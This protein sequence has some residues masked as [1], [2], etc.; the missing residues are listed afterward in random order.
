VARTLLLGGFCHSR[1][2]AAL[3]EPIEPL[4]I[5]RRVENRFVTQDDFD[6]LLAWFHPDR[7]QAAEEYERMRRKLIFYFRDSLDSGRLADR[8]F[9]VVAEKLAAGE[10]IASKAYFRAVAWR[11]R[12]DA[13]QSAERRVLSLESIA[14]EAASGGSPLD[15]LQR[16]REER[17]MIDALRQLPPEERR[18]LVTSAIGRVSRRTLARRLGKTEAA[19]NTWVHRIRLKLR[20]L[21]AREVEPTASD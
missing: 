14:E 3:I 9:D 7:N 17:L 18:V 1:R 8:V 4:G 19:L 6:R 21:V 10:A 5:A 20:S 2:L 16:T 12:S 11:V 15:S 13:W